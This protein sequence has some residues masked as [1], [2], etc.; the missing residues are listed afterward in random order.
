MLD[1][2]IGMFFIG[3]GLCLSFW[4]IVFLLFIIEKISGKKIVPDMGTFDDYY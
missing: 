4:A 2:I 3:I 1:K